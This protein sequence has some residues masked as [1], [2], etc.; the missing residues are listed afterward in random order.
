MSIG[1]GRPSGSIPLS[2]GALRPIRNNVTSPTLRVFN[3]MDD[4]L[5]ATW[6]ALA[7]ATTDAGYLSQ[8]EWY[9]GVLASLPSAQPLLIT[10]WVGD[11]CT[12]LIGARVDKVTVPMRIGYRQ[13]VPLKP[14]TLQIMEGALLGD[15][16]QPTALLAALDH[17]AVDAGAHLIT[18]PRLE[19][20]HPLAVAV[21]GE[22]WPWRRTPEPGNVHHRSNIDEGGYD[23]LMAGSKSTRKRVRKYARTL[24]RDHEVSLDVYDSADRFDAFIAEAMPIAETSYQYALGSSLG[25]PGEVDRLR[26]AADLG[27]F[28]GYLLRVDGEAW[29]FDYGIHHGDIFTAIATAYRQE[30]AKKRPG[31]IA[32]AAWIDDLGDIGVNELDWGPG[33]A[34]YKQ[35]LSS[36]VTDER[37]FVLYQ[38]TAWGSALAVLAATIDV[39]DRLGRW[40]ASQAGGL[41]KVKTTLRRRLRSSE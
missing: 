6:R 2:S 29:T 37:A 17:A 22:R 38:R 14:T 26:R 31:N 28:R 11:I 19:I 35:S 39:I 21:R 13:V 12:A 5:R 24:E 25:T 10:A 33:D 34:E 16:D 40:I 30:H 41:Q 1:N 18:F 9:E 20:S 27:W 32:L 36:R 4:E 3:R 7:A 15:L 23:A 8:P